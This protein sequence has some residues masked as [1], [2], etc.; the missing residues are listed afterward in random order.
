MRLFAERG[1]RGTSVAEIEA[2]AGLRPGSG[3]MYHHFSSKEAVLAEGVAR[4]LA[5]LDALRD[6]RRVFGG[7]GDLRV[8]LL[9]T[10]RY[11]LTELDSQT[12]LLRLLLSEARRQPDLL[13]A[14][15]DQLVVQTHEGFAEWL[16]EAAPG[17]DPGRLRAAATLGLASLLGSRLT[18]DV[19]GG[20][21][22]AVDDESL[23]ATW[24]D[25]MLAALA[26]PG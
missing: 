17:V 10:A 24:T 7:L 12:E 9:I 15:V 13:T 23:V 1:Y 6:I 4:H 11:Y 3:G 8:A 20:S 25:M 21:P 22:L 16:A 5:R 19:L 18:R 14:A 2:A 26:T